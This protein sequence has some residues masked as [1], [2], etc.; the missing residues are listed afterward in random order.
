MYRL[1]KDYLNKVN[2]TFDMLFPMVEAVVKQGEGEPAKNLLAGVRGVKAFE[3]LWKSYSSG[4]KKQLREKWAALGLPE[5]E[6]K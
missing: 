6:L 2:P 3:L 1:D 4:E 5:E